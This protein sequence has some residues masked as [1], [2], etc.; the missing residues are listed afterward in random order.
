MKDDSILQCPGKS[1]LPCLNS[2]YDPFSRLALTTGHP[3]R[4]DFETPL[5]LPD[6]SG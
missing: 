5:T 1:N 4:Q 2:S 3:G 6:P